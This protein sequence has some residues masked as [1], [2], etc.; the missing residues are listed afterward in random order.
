M[1]HSGEKVCLTVNALITYKDKVLLVFHKDYQTWFPPGG[2]VEKDED[3]ESAVYREIFEETGLT[4]NELIPITNNFEV[5]ADEDIFSDMGG[6]ILLSP[7]YSDIHTIGPNREHVGLRFFFQS[8]KE[9]IVSSDT[10]ITEI[11]WFSKVD[12][13]NPKYNLRKHVRFYG[14]KAIE[15]SET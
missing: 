6:R 11:K 10:D 5:D 8:K 13:N 4:K 14:T 3:P 2:H 15:L 9:D 1:S 7:L 12:L